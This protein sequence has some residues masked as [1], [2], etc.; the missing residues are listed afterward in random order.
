[1]GV[2]TMRTFYFYTAK[3]RCKCRT[4]DEWIHVGTLCVRLDL[5]PHRAHSKN[6]FFHKQCMDIEDREP[7]DR[8]KDPF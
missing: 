1:M 3:R 4:C 7:Y 8:N 2:E 6:L 5:I